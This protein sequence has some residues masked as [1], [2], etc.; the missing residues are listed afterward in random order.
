MSPINTR[1]TIERLSSPVGLLDELA[2][3]VRRGLLGPGP[4]WLPPKYFYDA[5]G[6]EL[7]EEITQLPEYYPTRAELE[8]LEEVGHDWIATVGPE[9]LVEL[10]SGSSRKTRLLLEAMHRQGSGNRYVPFD[11]SADALEAAAT[12]LTDAYPWLDVAGYVG[13]F[14]TDLH[15]IPHPRGRRLVTFLGSTIGNFLADRRGPLLA[16]IRTM[17]APGDRFLVG[18]DLVKDERILVAAYDDRAGVTAAFNRNMLVNLNRLGEADFPVE[19]FRHRAVWN[20]DCSCIEMRLVASRACTV[21]FQA[22][23]GLQVTFEP[24][25]ELLTEHSCKFTRASLEAELADGGLAVERW[26]TDGHD[27]FALALVAPS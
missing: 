3:D 15:R 2:E 4:K 25:E 7:F 11:V 17:M 8:I 16:E 9:E 12:T 5:R 6:S 18:A 27:R 20:A 22:L 10:G 13:D 24:G 23:D 14:H 19:E 1:A 21:T 26:R